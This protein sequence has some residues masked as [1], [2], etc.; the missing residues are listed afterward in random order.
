MVPGNHDVDYSVFLSKVKDN[1]GTYGFEDDTA[2]ESRNIQSVDELIDFAQELK[3]TPRLFS[4]FNPDGISTYE[5]SKFA[6]K[7]LGDHQYLEPEFFIEERWF[8]KKGFNIFGISNAE[9]FRNVKSLMQDSGKNYMK[10]QF[11]T[12]LT[13][14]SRGQISLPSIFVGH[15]SPVSLGVNLICGNNEDKCTDGNQM[16]CGDASVRNSGCLRASTFISALR[17]RNAIMYLFGHEHMNSVALSSDKKI[18]NIGVSSFDHT[19]ATENG[20]NLIEI[21]ESIEKT[22]VDVIHCLYNN[23]G[24]FDP[25]HPKRF[26]YNKASKQWEAKINQ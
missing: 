20:C 17:E 16:K 1:K 15:A 11:A 13:A 18:L 3:I 7:L 5:F 22:C 24:A 12:D 14:K 9:K 4:D 25:Q 10:Y 23:Q 8:R 26:E 6:F 2:F 21:D 19:N